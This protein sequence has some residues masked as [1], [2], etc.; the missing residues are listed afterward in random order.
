MDNLGT[1]ATL[2]VP[3]FVAVMLGLKGQAKN[4]AVWVYLWSL[5]ALWGVQLWHGYQL[6]TALQQQGLGVRGQEL[7]NQYDHVQWLS[8]CGMIFIMALPPFCY[9]RD[10]RKEVALNSK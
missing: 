1:W 9:F 10:R 3:I 2:S 4:I 6:E 8:I 7:Q 5:C